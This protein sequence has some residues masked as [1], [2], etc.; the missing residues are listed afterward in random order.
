MGHPFVPT[1]LLLWALSTAL[2]ACPMAESLRPEHSSARPTVTS[3]VSGKTPAP[4]AS[5]RG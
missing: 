3:P 4:A 2:R 1:L 5:V